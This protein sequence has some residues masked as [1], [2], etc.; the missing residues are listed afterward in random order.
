MKFSEKKLTLKQLELRSSVA[1][2][3]A[4]LMISSTRKSLETQM[5][6]VWDSMP[7]RESAERIKQTLDSL[8]Y[9]NIRE[10]EVYTTNL[11]KE[12]EGMKITYREPSEGFKLLPSARFHAEIIR[13]SRP[14][15]L[16]TPELTC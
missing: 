4:A 14:I 5:R 15:I 13:G 12:I 2:N 10:I 16:L 6:N 7:S 9:P 1:T 3:V 8:E 11:P